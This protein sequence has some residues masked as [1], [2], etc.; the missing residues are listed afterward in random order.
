MSII[1]TRPPS[2]A[3]QRPR[4]SDREA[5]HQERR[6][7]DHPDHQRVDAEAGRGLGLV[8]ESVAD[9]GVLVL[10][11][12][13]PRLVPVRLRR[14]EVGVQGDAGNARERGEHDRPDRQAAERD[15][16]GEAQ[17]DDRE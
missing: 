4:P 14:A 6:E 10:D 5:Q 11:R 8:L 12:E 15:E 2:S 1:T 3:S 13:Q 7:R 9:V 17:R 16:P